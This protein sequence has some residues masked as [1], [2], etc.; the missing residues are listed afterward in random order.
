VAAARADRLPRAVLE[1][2]QGQTGDE[3]LRQDRTLPEKLKAESSGILAWAVRGCLDWQAGGL[4]IPEEV[5]ASTDE[6]RNEQDVIASFLDD[7]CVTGLDVYTVR[8]N[9]LYSAYQ[10]WCEAHGEPLLKQRTFGQ[11]LTR[12]GF[13][14]HKNNGV[15]YLR[16]ALRAT[17]RQEAAAAN[18]TIDCSVSA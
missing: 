12:K 14:R 9:D 6:F 1:S 13:D 16:V 8:A 11:H 17:T 10:D 7:C 18:G 3:E 2:G 15:W 4:R 5:R